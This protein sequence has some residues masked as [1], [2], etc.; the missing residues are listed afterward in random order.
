MITYLILILCVFGIASGQ[1]LF[2]L[3]ADSLHSSGS[4]FDPNT[5]I[6][7]FFGLAVYGLTTIAWVWVLQKI[8]LGRAYPLMALAFILV[9]I[10]SHLILG[11]RFNAQYFLGTALIIAGILTIVRA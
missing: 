2:K 3:S 11:E 9:P 5:A 4:I 10:G 7:L 6:M 1:I 8:E